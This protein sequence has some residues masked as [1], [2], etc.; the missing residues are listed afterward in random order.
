MSTT[1]V[2]GILRGLLLLSFV[3]AAAPAIAQYTGEFVICTDG[4]SADN[5][6]ATALPVQDDG[7]II[8]GR[9]LGNILCAGVGF[10]P[11]D[12]DCF[13]PAIRSTALIACA[14]R[15]CS[16]QES[17]PEAIW[18]L[19]AVTSDH[20]RMGIIRRWLPEPAVSTMWVYVKTSSSPM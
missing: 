14:F 5:C 10:V 11:Q 7:T 8:W 17:L 4:S 3:L 9:D 12:V 15:M 1:K 20:F 19:L 2:S 16:A 13:S 6:R 18:A